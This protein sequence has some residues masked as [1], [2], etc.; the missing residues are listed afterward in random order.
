MKRFLI[1]FAS[2]LVVAV[3]LLAMPSP[4]K[5][6]ASFS[7]SVNDGYRR[8]PMRV[9]HYGRPHHSFRPPFREAHYAP[10][11]YAPPPRR[12]VYE[13]TVVQPVRYVSEAS[14]LAEPVSA[15]YY[16]E[17]GQLCREYQTMGRVGGYQEAAYGTACL[18]PDGAWRIV[19]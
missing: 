8:P 6:D 14:L 5:A 1:G 19:D 3:G 9:E 15:P 13:T 12:I 4:A 2:V 18:Q 7:F 11:W 16:D 17:R 10:Y